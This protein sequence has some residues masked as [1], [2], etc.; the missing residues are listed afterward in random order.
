MNSLTQ[1]IRQQIPDDP[2]SDTQL[3]WDYGEWA[4]KNRP[5]LFDQFPD[6][7]SEYDDIERQ[8]RPGLWAEFKG[9]LGSA[10]DNLQATTLG[11]GAA[12]SDLVGAN[13]LRD[14]LSEAAKEQERQA[15]EYQPSVSSF[16]DIEGVGDALYYGAMGAGQIAPSVAES[17]AFAVAGGGIGGIGARMAVK[18][19]AEGAAK[20][21]I[22]RAARIGA[23]AGLAAASVPPAIG[24]IYNETGDAALSMWAGTLSGA[25]DMI[26]EG[27]IVGKFA[28]EG[29]RVTA[30]KVMGF[31]QYIKEFAKETAKN[32][33]L[34]I[35]GEGTTEAAQELIGIAAAKYN[36]G[37]DP[38]NL[39]KEDFDRMLNAGLIGSIG[40]GVFAPVGTIAD[41]RQAPQRETLT[42][43]PQSEA[44]PSAQQFSSDVQDMLAKVDA[45]ITNGQDQA[46]QAP[47]PVPVPT[48][49]V[50][51]APDQSQIVLQHAAEMAS[52]IAGDNAASQNDVN[53]VASKAGEFNQAGVPAKIA[54]RGDVVGGDVS[55]PTATMGEDGIPVLDEGGIKLLS[56]KTVTLPAM[57]YQTNTMVDVQMDAAEAWNMA[58]D[59]VSIYR[60]I[61]RCMRA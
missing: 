9:S 33:G 44:Q 49:T 58:S 47:I 4:K 38:T 16:R 32:A 30:E 7:K 54:A 18:G 50:A 34:T 14:Y 52:Q 53:E 23:Q 60:N 43:P 12:A 15:A 3:T 31:R 6:F 21:A 36:R 26:P 19:A 28:K 41:M 25:L 13:R 10:A 51:D 29:T 24:E 8:H 39:T 5:D 20:A 1:L 35:P 2:R 17:A 22:A 11:A 42:P 56:G 57:N 61:I 45:A 48:P 46:P 59:R 40:G 55:I 27:Y 37:E